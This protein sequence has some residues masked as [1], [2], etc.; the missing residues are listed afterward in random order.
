MYVQSTQVW[1]SG[2]CHRHA[3]ALKG[4]SPDETP[5]EQTDGN[6]KV[7]AGAGGSPERVTKDVRKNKL[8][9]FPCVFPG[10]LV[11]DG[12]TMGCTGK[13]G[14]RGIQEAG[15]QP[16]GRPH[17]A[18]QSTGNQCR[19]GVPPRLPAPASRPSVPS[20]HPAPPSHPGVPPRRPLLPSHPCRSI[21]PSCPG[22]PSHLPIPLPWP[23]AAPP[24]PRNE[25]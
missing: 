13:A 11:S 25:P 19:H 2:S 23:S 18:A 22:F 21:L 10:S 4:G 7:K 3:A 24:P 12:L 9:F 15:A 6:E 5:T 8:L 14:E 1:G 20:S 17:A 16:G